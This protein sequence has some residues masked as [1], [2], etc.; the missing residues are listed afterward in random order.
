[1]PE[2]SRSKI[3]NK[4]TVIVDGM[5]GSGKSAIMSTIVGLNRVE[6]PRFDHI[7]EY[8]CALYHL[9]KIEIDGAIALMRIYSDLGCY[10][11][12]LSRELNFRSQDISGVL[13][14]PERIQYVARLFS[15]DGA[16]VEDSIK[17]V[18]PIMH[19][20]THQVF[21]I[22]SPIW[23]SFN[24][25]LVFIETV[26]H[27]LHL[28]TAWHGYIERY[29]NDPRELTVCFKNKEKDL[30]WFAADWEDLYCSCNAMEK[31]IRCIANLTRLSDKQLSGMTEL[32][33][34]H[35]IRIPFEKYV[36]EPWSYIELIENLLETQRRD[37]LSSILEK[38]NIPRSSSSD[39]IDHP[40]FR[41]YGHSPS[42]IKNDEESELKNKW[43]WVESEANSAALDIL[44]S[45]CER[46]ENEHWKA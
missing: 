9:G 41:R 17:N 32:Q 31:S 14:H 37:S 4:K 12:M 25:N 26:R 28:L 36:H 30:P 35:L 16:N 5:S 29:G 43:K 45:I 44:H 34:K 21:G 3:I 22:S 42:E 10:N 40:S 18:K 20:M 13:N 1:M 6:A 19:I 23:Q 39:T 24:E 33:K 46:Y 27:P 11:S 38:Q 15:E 2:L 7:Y 8:L